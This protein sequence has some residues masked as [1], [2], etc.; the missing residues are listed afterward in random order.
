MSQN[1]LYVKINDNVSPTL[2]DQDGQTVTET[3]PT[4]NSRI[5][6]FSNYIL[7][8]N[9]DKIYLQEIS[10]ANGLS[11]PDSY[12]E[13]DPNTM[14]IGGK[15]DDQGTFKFITD[16]VT[17]T[18]QPVNIDAQTT[19]GSEISIN[20]GLDKNFSGSIGNTASTPYSLLISGLQSA[21]GATIPG[22]SFTS[23]TNNND[24][25]SFTWYY[26][27]DATV[28]DNTN[29]ANSTSETTSSSTTT[30]Q[31]KVPSQSKPFSDFAVYA[32][33]K[34]GL[35]NSPNFSKATR[36]FWYAKQIRTKRPQFIVIGYAR[37]KAGILRYKV[38][39]I[40]RKS[41][42]FKQRG[43]I[44][45]DVADVSNNY[46]LKNPKTV[47]VIGTKGVNAYTHINLTGKAR[48][49]F[50]HGSILKVKALKTYHLTTRLVLNNGQYVTANKTLVQ[51][52]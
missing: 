36:K 3:L 38:R 29:S 48:R 10:S 1:Q 43:Y 47:L 26:S 2:Y 9:T 50:K 18:F 11:I 5:Y 19:I 20:S 52:K 23:P 17:F 15:T 49:H 46:Y 45:T 42:T 14:T 25:P 31:V 13:F 7:D 4:A 22:Y 34:I 8:L 16:P 24:E 28:P 6:Q 51:K 39:D 44:T 40:N 37:N 33:K 27:K 12:F 32:T 41:K 30:S 35:Y 21:V